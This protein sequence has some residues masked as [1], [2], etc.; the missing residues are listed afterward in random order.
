[1]TIAILESSYEMHPCAHT[2]I[3]CGAQITCSAT[4]ANNSNSKPHAM[5]GRTVQEE[6][7]GVIKKFSVRLA[8]PHQ[9]VYNIRVS[10]YY[11]RKMVM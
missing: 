9:G 2:M 11:N 3:Y 1:M 8:Q 5:R 4:H 10:L 6:L 7:Q